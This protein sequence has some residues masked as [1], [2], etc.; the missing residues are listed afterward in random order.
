MENGR[1]VQELI[2]HLKSLNVPNMKVGLWDDTFGVENDI[3][4]KFPIVEMTDEAT[5]EQI[6]CLG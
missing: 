1:T 5:G 3:I 6:I 2:D 4:Y